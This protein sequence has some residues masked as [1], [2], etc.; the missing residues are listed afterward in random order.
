MSLEFLWYIPNQVVPG[1]RGEPVTAD[2]NSLDTLTAHAEALEANGW[3][4]ALLGTG[5][6]RP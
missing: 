6:G 4:G 3:K 5:W 2:H 1:H